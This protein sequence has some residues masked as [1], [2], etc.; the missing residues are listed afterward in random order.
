MCNS[1]FFKPYSPNF[2]LILGCVLAR[3]FTG[4]CCL[5]G[6][7]FELFG[8]FIFFFL[9]FF[10]FI[11]LVFC[12]FFFYFFFFAFSGKLIFA[13]FQFSTPPFL[14]LLDLTALLC[15]PLEWSFPPPLTFFPP[16]PPPANYPCNPSA[17]QPPHFLWNPL[18]NRIC[19]LPSYPPLVYSYP[20]FRL[21]FPSYSPAI[22]IALR[23]K[24]RSLL[25]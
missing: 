8:I 15:V 9:I 4:N 23:L 25:I 17:T 3:R 16:T 19:H 2:F 18:L 20:L 24:S 21:F 14:C 11:F 22:R 6:W 1:L 5:W 7:I 12:F 10:L 13:L